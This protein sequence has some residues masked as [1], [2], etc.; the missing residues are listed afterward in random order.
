MAQKYEYDIFVSHSHKDNVFTVELCSLLKIA[1]F[2]YCVDLDS[3]A[4]GGR[5]SRDVDN[6]IKDSE[7]F[8]VIWSKNAKDD[9]NWVSDEID[10]AKGNKKRI[11]FICID[12]EPDGIYKNY[13]WIPCPDS[14]ITP[15]VFFNVLTSVYG[16]TENLQLKNDLYVSL[17]WS[18]EAL[19]MNKKVFSFFPK[20]YRLVGDDTN[21]KTMQGEDGEDRLRRIMNT[22]CG[23]VGIVPYR[24]NVEYGNTSKYILKEIE[25]AKKVGLPMLLFVDSRVDRKFLK[26]YKC[27]FIN[28]ID[29]IDD[30]ALETYVENF[31]PIKAK[32]PHI[33]F[34]KSMCQDR[35]HINDLIIRLCGSVTQVPCSVGENL[36]QDPYKEIID[37]IKCSYLMIDDI[38]VREDGKYNSIIEAGI[39][40]GGD[41][42]HLFLFEQGEKHTPVFMFRKNEPDYFKDD[43][44]LLAYIHGRIRFFRRKVWQ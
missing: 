27:F 30:I 24:D 9:S 21:Q 16:C 22:C 26:E 6:K 17:S 20:N 33:F 12:A 37:R 25:L 2:H 32:T 11:V 35:K 38:T 42:Q 39:A 8:L 4:P 41:V 10:I 29:S 14:K 18:A 43:C 19:D 3:M 40:L 5:I 44:E 1:Q 7:N 15:Q 13:I 31:E 23:F 34:A 28:D 36:G